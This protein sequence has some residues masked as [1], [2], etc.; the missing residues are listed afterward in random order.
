MSE[1]HAQNASPGAVTATPAPQLRSR[2]TRVA[3]FAAAAVALAAVLGYFYFKTQVGDYKRQN[4]VMAM[5][6]ELKEI[7]ARWDVDVL[8]ARTE[9]AP[10]QLPSPDYGSTLN[11]IRRDLAAATKEVDS[12]ALRQGHADLDNAFSQKAEMVDKFKKANTVT[13]Q[14]LTQVLAADSEIAGLVR[15][16]WQDFRDRERLV[17]AE[18]IVTQLIAESQKYYFA[19]GEAQKKTVET[20]ASDL[21]EA[22][23]R[24]PASLREGLLRLDGNVQHLLGAKPIEQ[25][26]YQKLS[27]VTAGPRV[28]GLTNAY[29]RELESTL[30]EKEIYRV[31]M[32][33]FSGAL[34]ILIGYLTSRLIASYRL[35]NAANED[36]ERRVIERTREL[37]EAL[38]QLKESEVQLIQT[39]KMSSLGQ[40]VAGVAHEINT[41]LAYAKNSLGSVKSKLP[42]LTQLIFE[43]EQ[44][45]ALLRSGAG[46]PQKLA[47]QFALTEKLLAQFRDHQALE[48]LQDLVKDGLYGIEQITE[49]VSNLKDFSRLDRS[50]VSS[51]NLNE[52][53]DSTLLLAKH[54]LKMHAVKK[55]YGAI[56]PITCSPSQLNQ[57]FLN[58]I[59][60]AAQATEAGGGVITLTTRQPDAEHVAVDI[61][62]NGKGIPPEVLPKIF[63]PFFT[64]K[65]VGKGTGLGL[66]IVYKIVEQHGGTISADSTVGV[67]TKFT[68]VLPLTP[69][70]PAPAA[71]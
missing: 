40:M 51:F 16:T 43:A 25:E 41:P 69:P 39:E 68:V 8:R 4:E 13:K 61:E 1:Q 57:V 2:L 9:I 52:G 56:P 59:N 47:Q 31:Y 38:T 23:L 71:A 42:E 48:E 20:V 62:D 53:L 30:A 65:D 12:P 5:L 50:K 21:R 24:L 44:L 35:I 17:A 3:L 29:S 67:G 11:R 10:L 49:I 32:V 70:E 26:L 33:A 14:A 27:F 34:L 45:L 55:N 36:L 15:G 64:T 28:N 60:N 37:S 63:D 58:L 46:D 6:R 7:D 66:S 54:D 22:A 18:N 19:S